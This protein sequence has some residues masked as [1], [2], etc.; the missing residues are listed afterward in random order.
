MFSHHLL[1]GN[2]VSWVGFWIIYCCVICY[3]GLKVSYVFSFVKNIDRFSSSDLV[4]AIDNVDVGI[5]TLCW[6]VT[7]EEI[8][9]MFFNDWSCYFNW[10]NTIVLQ[11]YLKCWFDHANC[12]LSFT[13]SCASEKFSIPL[14]IEIFFFVPSIWKRKPLL[15]VY[16]ENNFC[17]QKSVANYK[18]VSEFKFCYL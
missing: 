5:S 7:C 10:Y 3:G 12:C 11:R 16:T 17:I 2:A 13:V 15:Y 8:C 4:N 14:D 9:H 1:E 6:I 18:I